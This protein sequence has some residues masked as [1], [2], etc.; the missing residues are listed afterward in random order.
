MVRT[1]KLE[2]DPEHVLGKEGLH[3]DGEYTIPDFFWEVLVCKYPGYA[4]S[5]SCVNKRLHTLSNTWFC[6]TVT[7]WPSY[8]FSR[9]CMEDMCRLAAFAKYC[10]E[11][12][13]Q[14]VDS[15]AEQGKERKL[16]V[17][18]QTTISL[19]LRTLENRLND[20]L[21]LVTIVKKK[22]GEGYTVIRK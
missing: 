10:S 17:I 22:D 4:H 20:V 19:E 1:A 8:R 14:L 2:E 16:S 21:K 12:L 9:D 11:T 15:G 3:V 7:L 13:H 6:K 18:T 5:L